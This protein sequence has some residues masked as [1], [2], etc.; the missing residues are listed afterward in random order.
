MKINKETALHFVDKGTKSRGA[1]FIKKS[2][3]KIFEK[4][5]SVF[6]LHFTSNTRMLSSCIKALNFGLQNFLDFS[7]QQKYKKAQQSKVRK[8]L[9]R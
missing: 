3:A 1:T 6:E 2:A 8:L 9:K 5:S 7:L 4:L